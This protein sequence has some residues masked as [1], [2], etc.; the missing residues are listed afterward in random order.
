MGRASTNRHT[1]RLRL[2]ALGFLLATGG[3]V[4]R[5]FQLQ[6]ID[7][8]RYVAEAQEEHAGYRKVYA[9]R[10]AILD[11]N[12]HPLAASVDTFD[13]FI[14]RRV[15]R[16][17]SIAASASRELAE[18]I[19]VTPA[20]IRQTVGDDDRGD[21][22]LLKGVDYERGDAIQ[23]ASLPGVKV[24]PTSRRIYPEGNLA[25][26]V[27][28]FIGKDPVGLSGIEADFDSVLAGKPGTS[29]FERDS[30]GNDIVIGR[31]EIQPPEPGPNLVLTIDR[32]IQRLAEAELDATI[33]K[34][35]ASGGDIIVMD[36]NSGAILAMAT[37]PSFNL[38]R[39]SVNGDVR[40]DLFR[41]RSVTDLYEP[42][43]VL[44]L[45][46]MAAAIDRGI[47]SPDTTY[48]DSGLI[49]VSDWEIR[50]W[51]ERA[52]GTQ[53][54]A[55]VLQYSLNTGAAWVAQ[56]LGTKEFYEYMAAFGMSAPT[57]VGLAGE[58]SG[59]YRTPEDDDWTRVDLATNSFGQGIAVTPLQV[60]TAV[61]AIVNGGNLMRPYLV[62]EVVGA[63]HQE[64][65]QPQV[66]RRVIS[67]DA[68]RTMRRMMNEVV[69]GIPGHLAQVPGYSVGGK[70]GTAD[71]SSIS[72][73]DE[74][75]TIASFVG[76]A[77][78][79]EPRFV[80][81]VKID[82]PRDDEFGSTVAA[83]VFG[84]LAPRILQYLKVP[85]QDALVS[86]AESSS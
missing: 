50:N 48:Y 35:E 17:A 44:K 52:Y 4:A 72:G 43:S 26:T 23:K 29:L 34:H 32:S 58:A 5:L 84:R 56:Q 64:V 69:D 71:I 37:R 73:Y 75:T 79:D 63:G 31:R 28:G 86:S 82:G 7:H 62:Q 67:E 33:K 51:D 40:L 21:Q 22:L 47:V 70:T 59:V 54:M 77:P 11:R 53:T 46:T 16:D 65:T 39:P 30:L 38:L 27:I 61:G 10:G 49:T 55:Q 15:W 60:V 12:G 68:S 2:L 76:V 3:I 20:Q 8:D 78:A 18:I 80:M 45:L 6:V 57:N 9:P 85:P 14:E 36:P 42:G 25:A 24:I 41:N 13:V 81:L 83:P 74:A 19:D 1:W 66:V